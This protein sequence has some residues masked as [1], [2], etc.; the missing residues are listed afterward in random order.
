LEGQCKRNPA[1]NRS[2]IIRLLLQQAQ[3]S[4]GFWLP[5]GLYN[6]S[7]TG[8]AEVV[9]F[10]LTTIPRMILNL[11]ILRRAFDR[12]RNIQLTVSRDDYTKVLELLKEMIS[13]EE[14][15]LSVSRP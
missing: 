11:E 15:S 5:E 9:E 1:K 8:N 13:A 7:V 10:M 12:T 3:V 14:F 2:E 4:N 6:A